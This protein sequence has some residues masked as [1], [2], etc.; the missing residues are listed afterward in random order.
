VELLA[1]VEDATLRA[2]VLDTLDLCLGDQSN[3]WELAADG[4]WTRRSGERSAQA[5]LM[6]RALARTS[7]ASVS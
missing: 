3:A 1:P 2:E 4:T 6:A 7:E 5:E